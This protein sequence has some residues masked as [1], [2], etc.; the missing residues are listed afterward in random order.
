MKTLEPLSET[1]YQTPLKGYEQLNDKL[2][3]QLKDLSQPW[4]VCRL[5][6][7]R[8]PVEQYLTAGTW[9]SIV[10]LTRRS[11]SVLVVM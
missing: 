10:T 4:K 1:Q 6:V 9:R 3:E 11:L 7:T 2:N 8:R 5:A